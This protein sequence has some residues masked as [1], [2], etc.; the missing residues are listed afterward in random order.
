MRAVWAAAGAFA[1]AF[2]LCAT[3]VSAAGLAMTVDAGAFDRRNTVVPFLVPA[4][5]QGKSLALRDLRGTVLPLQADDRGRAV[6]VLAS[7]AAGARAAYILEER[8]APKTKTRIE[9]RREADGVQL[10][11]AGRPALRFQSAG[12]LP[13]P[14][15]KPELLRGGYV[16]PVVTPSGL[17]VTDDYPPGHLHHHGIWSAWTATTFEGR[18]P[19][20]WEMAFR[21]GRVDLENV[22]LVWD[23]PLS[24]GVR[25]HNIFVDLAPKANKVAMREEVQITAYNTHGD[26][27]PYFLF[28][29]DLYQTVPE[30]PLTLEQYRYGGI[31]L[32]GHREWNGK[33]SAFFLTSEG[34][35]RAN[36]NAT[37]ARWCHMGGK[38][39]GRLAGVAV[40][41]HPG[42]LRSPQPM[43]IHPEEPFFNY[44]PVQAGPFTIEPGRPFVARYRFVVSDGPPDRRLLDRLWND[45]AYPPQVRLRA[46]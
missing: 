7:L 38:V 8:D 29:V 31:G 25:G 13:R 10:F 32:R 42:N 9:A 36:G 5:L 6:F 20:F 40:L 11:V 17:L 2:V 12:K 41:G 34:K 43:R 18:R 22:V 15:I 44:A 14:D 21:T 24:G 30:S 19:N 45:Y 26:R 27:A 46:R 39:G 1:V 28:D 4:D 16:H 35:T 37:T 3:P 23:G 33:D